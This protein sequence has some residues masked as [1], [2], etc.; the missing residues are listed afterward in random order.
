MTLLRRAL[1]TFFF[2]PTV[3]K[4]KLL[5]K[6]SVPGWKRQFYNCISSLL[7]IL[8]CYMLVQ[9]ETGQACW[10]AARQ[11]CQRERD[12][13]ENEI[14]RGKWNKKYQDDLSE[15]WLKKV[16]LEEKI[17]ILF[18]VSFWGFKIVFCFLFGAFF[19]SN[20]DRENSKYGDVFQKWN[21]DKTFVFW[22]KV[23]H[24]E[25]WVRSE[26]TEGREGCVSESWGSGSIK[27]IFLL[28]VRSAFLGLAFYKLIN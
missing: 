1:V 13:I 8:L 19:S 6:K 21:W 26:G 15:Q 11:N 12:Q 14:E 23:E 5:S 16:K 20:C 18:C 4:G 3:L 17:P 25:I 7:C 24:W 2:L 27:V 22:L 10:I 9:E 28:W